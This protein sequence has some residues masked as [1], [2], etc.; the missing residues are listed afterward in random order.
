MAENSS[1]QH[2]IKS[3][4]DTAPGGFFI[5]DKNA[6]ILYANQALQTKTGYSVHETV[7]VNPGKLWGKQMPQKFYQKLWHVIK[8][9]K[10]PFVS[11]VKN[12]TKTGEVFDDTMRIA[13]IFDKGEIVY[14]IALQSS[15][16]NKNLETEFFDFMRQ[17]QQD[18]SLFVEKLGSWIL[19]AP[20]RVDP[21]FS[22]SEFLY[23]S[24]VA[25][26]QEVYKNRDEDRE[27]LL[28]AQKK[29][30]NFHALYEKYYKTIFTYFYRHLNG[31]TE[32]ASDFAQETFL[33]AFAHLSTFVPSNASYQTYLMRI[34]HNILVNYYRK[35]VS[36]VN[37]ETLLS[38]IP[39]KEQNK[40]V[41]EYMLDVALRKLNSFEQ[42]VIQDMYH[43]GLSVKEISQK[44]GKTENAVKLVL[45][46]ARKKLRE[47]L[48]D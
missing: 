48:Q 46:R 6:T 1:L 13:P 28:F 34:A 11:A 3:L 45:S 43:E 24:F 31:D 16:K 15:K 12:R 40:E 10:Q 4:F 17:G 42:G 39:A 38:L 26:T 14:Y 27:L 7:G 8:K 44:V 23:S 47:L 35:N 33:K 30:S 9:E 21:Q 37:D 36:L 29:I 22:T 32:A 41:E 19:E 18:T 2:S 25:P 20:L 5:T